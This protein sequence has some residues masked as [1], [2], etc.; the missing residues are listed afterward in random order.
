[1]APA[2]AK[3]LVVDDETNVLL[4][5][6]SILRQ[7][8]FEVDEANG[9]EKALAAIR[10]R[11]YDL[12]LTDLNMPGVN[13]MQVLAEVRKLSPSTVTVVITGYG[14]LNSALEAIQLGAYEYLL[15]PT[16]VEELKQAVRRSLDRKRL[17]ETETLYRIS[18]AAASCLDLD[19]IVRQI[20]EAGREV[21]A[22]RDISVVLFDA[23]G[24]A[25]DGPELGRLL[26][27]DALRE[28]LRAGEV[29]TEESK[30]RGAEEWAVRAGVR[31]Y[32]LVPGSAAGRL[33]CAICAWNGGQPYEFH[34]SALRFLQALAEQAALAI[35]NITLIEQLKR[36]NQEL[37][38]ANQKLRELDQLKSQFLSV[39]THELRT[40]LSILLGYNSMLEESLQDR[41]SDDERS[42]LAESSAA[43][44]RLIRLVNSMLDV[45]QIE[46]GKMHMNLALDDLRP[47]VNGVVKLFQHEA[48]QRGVALHVEMPSRLPRVRMD[49]ERLQQV[50][51]NLV[52]NALKFTP[53]GGDVNIAVRQ[54]PEAIEVSVRDSGVGIAPEDQGRI[55]D[56]FAQ[57]SRQASNRQREGSGLGLAIAKRIVQAHSGDI[58]V[59]SLLG[60]GSTFTFTLPLRS[61]AERA[62]PA[63]SA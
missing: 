58:R 22:L 18:R 4:T 42:T 25:H 39:A 20:S 49:A 43:C 51:I 14:S 37:A 35:E 45:T 54:R 34:A 32:A 8:G 40:P 47:V 28:K 12:V 15:K 9:G 6:T 24:Q 46:A 29:I 7:E 52:G 59:N 61:K 21:L 31:A 38:S 5:M 48:E 57:V 11:S 26:S 10:E 17:S 53:R 56:E 23:E 13:G 33:V 44:K 60:E 41:L 16:E 30:I 36:N 2:Q 62:F 50:F 1:M 63:A 19:R 55:F 3:I 27:Q